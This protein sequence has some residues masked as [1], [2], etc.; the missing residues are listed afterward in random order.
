[1]Q[2][3]TI[4]RKTIYFKKGSLKK[5]LRLKKNDKFTLSGLQRLQKIPIKQRFSFKGKQ[6]TMTLLMKRRINFAITL[7]K[8]KKRSKKK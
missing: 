8:M 6:F 2:S 3:I 4:G 7:M 5:Q 1:M